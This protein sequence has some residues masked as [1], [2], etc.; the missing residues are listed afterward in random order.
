MNKH[1]QTATS[2]SADPQL[3]KDF[4]ALCDC[5][6]RL[7]GTESERRAFALIRERGRLAS[8]GVEATSI[9][10]N[11][12]GWSIKR[13]SLALDDGVTLPCQPLLRTVA[14]AAQGLVA[15]VI[16]LGR[17][18]PEEFDA[19]ADD[20]GGRIVLV[21]HELMFAAGTIHRRRK[22]D[23]ARRHGAAGFLIAGPLP[24]AVVAGST[25]RDSADEGI[26]AVGISPEG[27]ARLRR[28]ERGWPAATLRIETAEGAA[29]TETLLFEL[30]GREDEWVVLSAHVDGHDLAE[31]AMDNAT[32][33]AAVLA[34]ARALAPSVS[35]F[36]RGLRLAFFS[37]EEW[38][39]TGSRQY[40]EAL[41][42]GA[43]DAIALNV[44]LDSIAGS[45]NLTALTSGFARL[46]PFLLR[47][48]E[49]AGQS[50]RTVRPLMVNSDH[51]SFAQAGIPAIRLVAGFD[52]PAANL[53]YVLTPADTRDKVSQ[54]ELRQAAMLSAALVEAACNANGDEAA[55]WRQR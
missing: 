37:V 48:A 7:C 50:L 31:S 40:V 41:T 42:P 26:P 36:Q 24:G 39:L 33:V 4:L 45:P 35:S 9:P 12:G 1:V 10:V 13:A 6:G 55:R 29:Q 46:E 51:A 21:R 53:R 14:T 32:G 11:Y 23:L 34:V 20:I 54:A 17:G 18:T 38:A 3:W 49:T 44:N 28:T 22:Y 30:P 19:H 2:L 16:D 8:A 47:V 5:G 25:G 27:A 43:R 52:D 15:E